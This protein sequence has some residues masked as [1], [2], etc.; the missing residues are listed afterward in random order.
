MTMDSEFPEPAGEE[1]APGDKIA[2][3]GLLLTGF[4]AQAQ[5]LY[6]LR[7]D[8][9][10]TIRSCNGVWSEL[11]GIPAEQLT[12]SPLWSHLTDRDVDQL[13]GR[14]RDGA[15][16]PAGAVPPERLRRGSHAAHAGM[17]PGRAPG[18][19]PPAGRAPALRHSVLGG[20]AGDGEAR[21]GE[22]PAILFQADAA[23]IEQ[24]L[25][26]LLGNAVKFTPEQGRVEVRLEISPAEVR[27]RV[28]DT[29]AGI[30]PGLLSKLFEPFRQGALRGERSSGGLPPSLGEDCTDLVAL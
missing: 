2:D 26:N 4:L 14:V 24:A 11:L 7:A 21:R 8:L 3:A 30:D 18:W 1:H 25:V 29:G 27:F 16:P 19:L 22:G 13:R 23:R 9:E 20:A 17:P 15:P 10:G 5:S 6:Y 12:G 28:V